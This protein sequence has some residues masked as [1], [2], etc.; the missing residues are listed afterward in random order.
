MDNDSKERPHKRPGKI[1]S[2]HW[3]QDAQEQLRA[4]IQADQAHTDELE[5]LA[6]IARSTIA[7]LENPDAVP[8]PDRLRQAARQLAAMRDTLN[9]ASGHAVHSVDRFARSHPFWLAAGGLV[10]GLVIARVLDKRE[11]RLQRHVQKGA[12]Q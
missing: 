1:I 5:A 8:S 12:L 6:Q 3:Q 4:R 9:N 10:A 11:R 2:G 7:D